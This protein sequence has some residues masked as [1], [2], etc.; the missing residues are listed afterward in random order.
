MLRVSELRSRYELGR[1]SQLGHCW[2]ELEKE[3]LYLDQPVSLSAEHEFRY[4]YLAG[5]LVRT[6]LGEDDCV[7]LLTQLDNL[8]DS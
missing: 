7:W 1:D 5:D 4:S 6:G 3:V 8:A 2:V